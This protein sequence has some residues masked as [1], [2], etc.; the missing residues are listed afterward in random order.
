VF[1]SAGARR[2]VLALAAAVC[3]ALLPACEGILGFG[4]EL[5]C[6]SGAANGPRQTLRFRDQK[7]VGTAHASRASPRESCPTQQQQP[8]RGRTAAHIGRRVSLPSAAYFTAWCLL[9]CRAQHDGSENGAS[10]RLAPPGQTG[11]SCARHLS[12]GV[13]RRSRAVVRMC[14]SFLRLAPTDCA[15][16]CLWC[17]RDCRW[18]AWLWGSKALKLSRSSRG[19]K[20]R[21]PTAHRVARVRARGV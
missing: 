13:Q 20:L 6:A 12:H 7:S 18:P 17:A 4:G 14:R 8:Q 19:P 21:C 3:L 16:R 11:A 10:Y 15:V 5:H 2:R 1:A 9:A